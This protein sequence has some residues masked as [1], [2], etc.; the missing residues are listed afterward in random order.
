MLIYCRLLLTR[1][2]K[3]SSQHSR[4]N[5]QKPQRN[6]TFMNLASALGN[7]IRTKVGINSNSFAVNFPIISFP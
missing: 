5:A 7:P 3:T 1:N 2:T 6:F 4:D